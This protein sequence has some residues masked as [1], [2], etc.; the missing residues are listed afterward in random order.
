MT[1]CADGRR[2]AA[3][4]E[5]ALRAVVAGA[6]E[7]AAAYGLA[8]AAK[9]FAHHDPVVDLVHHDLDKDVADR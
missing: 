4:T 9:Q 3:T 8:D 6:V 5:M 1:Q 2:H 7:Q